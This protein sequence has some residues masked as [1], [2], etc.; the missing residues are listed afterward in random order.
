MHANTTEYTE[1]DSE[2]STLSFYVLVPHLF[3]ANVSANSHDT[4]L[5]PRFEIL[6]LLQIVST[7][8]VMCFHFWHFSVCMWTELNI[9]IFSWNSIFSRGC[10]SVR[11]TV[12]HTRTLIFFL[13][14]TTTVTSAVL[15][16]CCPLLFVCS[17]FYVFEHTDHAHLIW[18]K[19]PVPVTTDCWFCSFACKTCLCVSG[20]KWR[21]S[22]VEF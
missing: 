19:E 8:S 16:T 14:R 1:L 22:K 5:F 2:F 9:T 21:A 3:R 6:R 17:F 11:V 10:I 20:H 12:I 4:N 18:K 13:K 15:M 7:W